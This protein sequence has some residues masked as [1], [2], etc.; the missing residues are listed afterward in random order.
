MNKFQSLTIAS[1]AACLIIPLSISQAQEHPPSVPTPPAPSADMPA[2]PAPERPMAIEIQQSIDQGIREAQREIRIYQAS[3]EIENEVRKAMEQMQQTLADLDVA[4]IPQARIKLKQMGLALDDA[5]RREIE[6]AIANVRH[7]IEGIDA[8]NM[9]IQ[10]HRILDQQ[11]VQWPE[12]KQV[13]TI[14]AQ[15]RVVASLENALEQQKAA[16]EQARASA[17]PEAE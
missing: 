11:Y 12:Q 13:M 17:A 14:E 16:L 7:R 8:E 5:D 6:L 15:E 1:L 10:I 3:G 2:P 4:E 9:V